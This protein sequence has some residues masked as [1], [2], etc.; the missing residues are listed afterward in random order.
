[1]RGRP[2]STI[3]KIKRHVQLP[4]SL[5]AE[6]DLLLYDPLLGQRLHGSWSSLITKLLDRWVKEQQK[7]AQ[8][9]N[10]GIND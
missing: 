6:V 5:V 10:A 3:K 4:E 8:E 2:P 9:P 1:M 7:G